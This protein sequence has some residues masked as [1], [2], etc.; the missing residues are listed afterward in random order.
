MYTVKTLESQD[1]VHTAFDRRA[2]W[3]FHDHHVQVGLDGALAD[4]AHANSAHEC[5]EIKRR[6]LQL[7]R[8]GWIARIG[9][10]VVEHGVEQGRHVRAPLLTG[11]A[12]YHRCPTVDA[13]GI[14]HRK[15]KLLVVGTE[16]VEQIKSGVH[17][18][19]WVGTGFV[20]FVHHDDGLEAQSQSLLGHEAGLGHGAFLRVDQQHHTVDHGQGAFHFAAEVRVAWGVHD[21]DVGPFPAHG[22]VFGQNGDAALTFDG[23]VVHDGVDDFF[24]VGEGA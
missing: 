17:H 22:A 19:V 11:C 15:V 9:F 4:A 24:V 18:F 6:N 13:G 20:D 14:H 21:V 3:A 10:D 5:G 7:Q 12:L 1:L 8:R 16:F 2:V 23:V